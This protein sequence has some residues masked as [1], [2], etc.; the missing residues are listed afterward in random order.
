MPMSNVYPDAILATDNVIVDV[1]S[2]DEARDIA[3]RF[4]ELHRIHGPEFECEREVRE[5][6]EVS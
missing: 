3:R 4:M 2:K 1:K 5:I 6:E